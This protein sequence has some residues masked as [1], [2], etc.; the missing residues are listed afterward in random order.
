MIVS[1]A[2]KQKK[3]FLSVAFRTTSHIMF[4]FILKKYFIQIFLN[5]QHRFK[6]PSFANINIDS[7]ET[8]LIF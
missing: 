6:E 4:D 8:M 1:E 5:I 3:K 7:V 2:L